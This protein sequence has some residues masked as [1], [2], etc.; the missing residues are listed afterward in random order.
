[1]A[2]TWNDAVVE[3]RKK[4]VLV[5]GPNEQ[6]EPKPSPGMYNYL[7]RTLGIPTTDILVYEDSDTG[8]KAAE[9]AGLE[10]KMITHRC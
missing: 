7:V 10:L 5:I 3:V 4:S 9:L 8:K 1:M 6:L 2:N